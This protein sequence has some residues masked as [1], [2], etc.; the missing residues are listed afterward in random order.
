VNVRDIDSGAKVSCAVDRYVEKKV[1]EQQMQVAGFFRELLLIRH[2]RLVLFNSV[3]FTRDGIE[4]IVNE[5]C[6]N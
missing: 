4:T 2:D 6:T 5:L 1:V 3:N